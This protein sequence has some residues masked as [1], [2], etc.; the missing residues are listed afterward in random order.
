MR[1]AIRRVADATG[2]MLGRRNTDPL[3]GIRQGHRTGVACND[4]ASRRGRSG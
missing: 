1:G 4:P 3:Y 2:L